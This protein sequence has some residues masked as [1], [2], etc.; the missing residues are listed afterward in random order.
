ML[1]ERE[2]Q[3]CVR[4]ISPKVESLANTVR[5]EKV[6]GKWTKDENQDTLTNI[7]LNIKSGEL[8]GIIGPVGSGKVCSSA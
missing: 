3:R 2:E 8:V 7:N 4:T 6:T 1:E 5:L